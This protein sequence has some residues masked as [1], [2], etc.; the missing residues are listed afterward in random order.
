MKLKYQ[1][2][3]SKLR[4]QCPSEEFEPKETKAFRWVLDEIENELNFLPQYF[5]NPARF[6]NKPPN[7][8][9]KSLGLSFFSSEEKARIR[10]KVLT[11]RMS[12]SVKGKIGKNVAEGT[13]NEKSKL[14]PNVNHL[15]N[16]ISLSKPYLPNKPYKYLRIHSN[17]NAKTACFPGSLCIS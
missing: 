11:A 15:M 16:L 1:K 9:C 8:K 12:A 17:V 13:I 14:I 4:L 7:V 2:I 3:I 6:E 10:F 5:K